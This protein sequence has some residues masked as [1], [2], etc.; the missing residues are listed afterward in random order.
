MP[1]FFEPR[2]GRID[3]LTKDGAGRILEEGRRPIDVGGTIPGEEVTFELVR[4]VK[5]AYVGKLLH[6]DKEANERTKPR[7]AFA[8]VCGGCKWQHIDYDGQL[9]FK[10][11]R[12]T[13]A[14]TKADL[15]PPT[16]IEPAPEIFFYR[17]RMD[18]V[19]GRDGQLG[20]RE[21]GKWWAPLDLTE[22]HLLSPETPSILRK[23][24]DLT[25]KSG[26]PFWNNKT[27]TGLFRYLVIREGK[28]TGERMIML[29]TADVDDQGVQKEAWASFL[30]QF[31]ATLDSFATSIIWGIN[32]TLTDTSFVSHTHVL[33]GD[34]SIHETVGDISYRISPN[35]FFQTNTVMA[36][37]LQEAVIEAVGRDTSKR[38]L[39]L[40]CGSGFFALA[41][42]LRG[43]AVTGVELVE[44]AIEAARINASAN[45]L[46]ADFFVSKAEDFDWEHLHPDVVIVDPPRAGLHP[47]AID[48][49]VRA[50]PPK[51]VYVS[52]NYPRLLDEWK[53][54]ADV[55]EIT[56]VQA[57][58][59]FPHT[60]HVEVLVTL[61]KKETPPVQVVQGGV[62]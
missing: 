40:Y 26:L 22:C 9:S 29:V 62:R 8:G 16:H 24:R 46:S 47:A 2:H 18:Y 33:K 49:L 14:F 37:V 59:L 53:A 13:D 17:N 44:E 50:C 42:A 21:A 32:P 10:L 12:L 57:F 60:P 52:C 27:N 6:V 56:S 28:R 39:D 23:V 1:P 55:Y 43:Y 35:A 7:C 25:Q 31:I 58:D 15:P 3:H 38:V 51:I 41:L 11:A 19:F 20:L 34:T 30:Q 48:T 4:K 54:F 36:E 5:G 61:Q 45:A